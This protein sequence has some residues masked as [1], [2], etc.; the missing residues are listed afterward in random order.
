MYYTS[1]YHHRHLY[2]FRWQD[3]WRHY[4]HN[5]IA[6]ATHGVNNGAFSVTSR[7]GS[8]SMV[9]ERQQESETYTEG[10]IVGI[11][12]A[13]WLIYDFVETHFELDIEWSGVTN[14]Y[15]GTASST[16]DTA[17]GRGPIPIST[18]HRET[19]YMIDPNTVS[20]NGKPSWLRHD[21]NAGVWVNDSPSETDHL[22]YGN[23]SGVGG[24]IKTSLL[25]DD[26]TPVQPA[27]PGVTKASKPEFRPGYPYDTNYGRPALPDPPPAPE[28]PVPEP[29]IVTPC[30]PA[31]EN[32]GGSMWVRGIGLLQTVGGAAEVVLGGLGVGVSVGGAPKTGGSSL[33]L[34]GS[35]VVLIG[36][37]LD[38]IGTGFYTMW[39]GKPTQTVTSQAI[40]GATGNHLA[41]EAGDAIIGI[42]LTLGVGAGLKSAQ[43]G[44]K[45]ANVAAKDGLKSN[46]AVRRAYV[47]EVGQLGNQSNRTLRDSAI[48][49]SLK[50]NQLKRK[51]RDMMA[52]RAAAAMLDIKD[53][54]LPVSFYVRKAYKEKGLVGDALW[55]EVLKGSASPNKKINTALGIL[56]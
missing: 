38:H 31:A 7:S 26:M 50:R 55:K 49:D 2:D 17:T 23:Y 32:A 18:H 22:R 33:M 8:E 5:V 47:D 53:P 51:W 45:G 39:T 40:E 20:P 48:Q 37:G 21:T 29:I 13:N 15:S 9:I 43:A 41:G 36:H 16:I 19:D 12:V 35:S 24:V 4:T 27:S 10:H 30:P 14:G 44:A 28:I 11:P 3:G 34:L 46:E 42:G 6:E 52:D 25:P 1:S 54:I 56:E